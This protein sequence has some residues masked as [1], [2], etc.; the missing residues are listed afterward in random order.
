[1]F[2]FLKNFGVK[3]MAYFQRAVQ[4]IR[5]SPDDPQ[6]AYLIDKIK[7]GENVFCEIKTDPAHGEQLVISAGRV[8]NKEVLNLTASGI[9]SPNTY[10]VMADASKFHVIIMLPPAAQY[11]GNLSIVCVDA[12]HGIELVVDPSTQNV[13]FDSSSISF[14]AKGDAINL[15]A[16]NKDPGT[17]FVVGRYASQWYA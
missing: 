15:I 6:A 13:I 17:W 14:H 5:I 16:D 8:P 9:V 1:M 7:L 4:T 11:F 3:T 2:G 12:S 10:L